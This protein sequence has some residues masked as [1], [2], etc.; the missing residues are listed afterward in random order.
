MISA[1]A[2]SNNN[3]KNSYSNDQDANISEKSES[4]NISSTMTNDRMSH[5]ESI[6]VV[7]VHEVDDPVNAD[8][9]D[10]ITT[11]DKDISED[12]LNVNLLT[13]QLK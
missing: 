10:S 9:D 4:M 3:Q 12:H 7:E 2:N 6:H 13:N 1:L 8:N 5:S 11:V